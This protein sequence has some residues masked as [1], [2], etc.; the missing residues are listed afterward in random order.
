M[1]VEICCGDIESVISAKKGGA[2]RIELCSA[3]SEGGVTP[4]SSLIKKAVDSEIEEINVLIRPRGG[5]FL[6]S[7]EELDLIL[8]DIESAIE[9]GATGIVIGA[10]TPE[11]DIDLNAMK[12]M[13][14]TV[15]QKSELT[16]RKINLTFHRAF[17]MARN[18]E[19][20]FQDIISLGFDC[21]LTSGQAKTVEEGIPLL[22]KLVELSEGK[23]TI[24]AGSGVKPSNVAKIIRETGVSAIHSSAS[25]LKNSQMKF[26]QENVSMGKDSE[27][28]RHSETSPEIVRNLIDIIQKTDN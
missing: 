9:L 25:E 1:E 6:Y 5:D 8:R 17:D 11:G 21:L 15:K 14:K 4:S 24:M 7:K 27:E 13:V 12:S 3:L 28:Y 20:A 18:P 10:L 22:K 19:K 2:R 23:I 26:I 16:G